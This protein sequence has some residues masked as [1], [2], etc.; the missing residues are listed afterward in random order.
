MARETKWCQN[1]K[2]PEKKNSNQIRGMKGEK[3]YQSNRANGY[4]NGNFCTLGCQTEWDS[5]YMD[6]AIDALNIRITEPVKVD[7]ENAWAI[8]AEWQ[9]RG[10]NEDNRYIYFLVND[11]YNIRH[12]ITRLQATGNNHEDFS[13]TLPSAQAKELAKQLGLTNQ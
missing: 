7:M 10:T 2:C 8:D 11:L 5:I 3:Y 9:F 12:P 13:P 4:G 6:R 1:P